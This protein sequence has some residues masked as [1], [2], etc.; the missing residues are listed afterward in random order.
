M[1]A[2]SLAF[3][4][5]CDLCNRIDDSMR[6]VGVRSVKS[7]GVAVNETAHVTDIHLVVFV[8]FGLAHFNVEVH[9]ALVKSSVDAVRDNAGS[10]DEYMLGLA[11]GKALR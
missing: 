5:R 6:I 11:R 2:D 4:Y 9:C 3:G 7:D 1:K 10:I 8:E